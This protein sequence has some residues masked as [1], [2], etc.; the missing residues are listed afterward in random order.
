MAKKL[1]VI[2]KDNSAVLAQAIRAEGYVIPGKG[3]NKI[4]RIGKDVS[5]F[6]LMHS[7]KRIEK[8]SDRWLKDHFL[9]RF[10]GKDYLWSPPALEKYIPWKDGQDYAAKYGMQ[11]SRFE[12][13]TLFDLTKYNPAI[14]EAAKVLELKTDDYYWTREPYAGN[15]GYAW[16]VGIKGGYVGYCGKDIKFYVR[17]VRS[18]Q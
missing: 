17:P 11:A 3:Q 1:E 18:S 6:E 5:F 13:N 9:S 7:P 14:I 12:F 10:Y 16:Y 15:P 4:L 8:L 2:I